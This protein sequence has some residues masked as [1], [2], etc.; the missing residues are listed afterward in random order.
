ML[1]EISSPTCMRASLIQLSRA[2]TER[3]HKRRVPAGENWGI[4]GKKD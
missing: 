3:K 2:H 4:R 1:Q